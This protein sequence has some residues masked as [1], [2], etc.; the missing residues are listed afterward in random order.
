ML[1]YYEAGKSVL[2]NLRHPLP[3][4]LSLVES[5]AVERGISLRSGVADAIGSVNRE[6]FFLPCFAGITDIDE[7]DAL[8]ATGNALIGM[9]TPI[10]KN[11]DGTFIHST[12]VAIMAVMIS[13]GLQAPGRSRALIIGSGCGYAPA[14]ISKVG[15]GSI[16]GIELRPGLAAISR[17][18]LKDNNFSGVQIVSANAAHWVRNHGERFDMAISFA[19]IPNDYNGDRALQIFLDHLS[20]DGVL[21]T[22]YGPPEHCPMTIFTQGSAQ[23]NPTS[24][25]ILHDTAFTPF[26]TP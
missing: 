4:I 2:L 1:P 24:R 6:T 7:E 8:S 20:K 5:Y 22:P 11:P 16:I 15:F 18:T 13:E 17:Q 14:I 12:D 25:I 19:A 9:P 26:I 3:S 10:L 21:V 23:G